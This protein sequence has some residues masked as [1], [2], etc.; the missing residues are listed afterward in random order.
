MIIKKVITFHIYS[1]TSQDLFQKSFAT[2]KP[3]YTT[4]LLVQ[5]TGTRLRYPR[6]KILPSRAGARSGPASLTRSPG[7][8]VDRLTDSC[9]S[10][11]ELEIRAAIRHEASSRASCGKSRRFSVSSKGSAIRLARELPSDRSRAA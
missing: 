10:K 2:R 8:G 11:S 5:R 9:D 6:R 7:G 1:Q 4:L 3:S